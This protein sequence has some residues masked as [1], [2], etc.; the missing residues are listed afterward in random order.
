[1][2][3]YFNII[4]F[5]FYKTHNKLHL[6]TKKLNPFNLIHKLPFQKKRYEKLGINIHEEI[7]KAFNNK[8][9]GLSIIVAG[10]MLLG[11]ISIFF[12]ALL[13]LTNIQ[14]SIPYII[15]CIVLGVIISYFFVFKDEKYIKYFDKY[16]KWSKVERQKYNWL[17]FASIVV[18]I[19][20]VFLGFK[21]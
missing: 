2:E 20:L 17:T 16:E 21:I 4:H 10:G 7:D 15:I 3:N 8:N 9:F 11:S 19:V 5:C 12:F 13:L 1:M 6:L 18:V 14:I